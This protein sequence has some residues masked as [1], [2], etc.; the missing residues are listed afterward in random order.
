MYFIS[1]DGN[2]FLLFRCEDSPFPLYRTLQVLQQ[3]RNTKSHFMFIHFLQDQGLADLLIGCCL[4]GALSE[5]F[6]ILMRKDLVLISVR[7]HIPWDDS[8]MSVIWSLPPAKVLYVPNFIPAV[9]WLAGSG[10][11]G[12]G[13]HQIVIPVVHEDDLLSIKL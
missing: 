10:S 8:L 5:Q 2:I 11:L 4:L 12:E 13:G 9:S 1:Y 7:H 3:Y 6:S